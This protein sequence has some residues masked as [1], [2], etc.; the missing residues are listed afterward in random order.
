MRTKTVVECEDYKERALVE[1][2]AQLEGVPTEDI[3]RAISRLDVT[4]YALR[5]VVSSRAGTSQGILQPGQVPQAARHASAG[6]Q[7][8]IRKPVGVFN[9]RP[10]F[11]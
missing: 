2:S 1:I 6:V 3:E 4:L 11:D 7:A 8:G 10:G 9:L 5:S